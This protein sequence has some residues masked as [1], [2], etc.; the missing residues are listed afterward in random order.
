M[1]SANNESAIQRILPPAVAALLFF[2][3]VKERFSNEPT[4]KP[5]PKPASKPPY[6]GSCH[7]LPDDDDERW[8]NRSFF[9]GRDHDLDPSRCEK[10][11][12]GKL[13]ERPHIL[14]W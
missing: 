1:S 9:L 10:R 14:E 8:G 6:H 11:A 3:F 5:T 13:E 2:L 4:S 12:Q 7:Q